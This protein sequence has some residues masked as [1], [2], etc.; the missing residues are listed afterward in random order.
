MFELRR[1]ITHALFMTLELQ[2]AVVNGQTETIKN[3]LQMC[4]S[5]LETFNFRILIDHR[6]FGLLLKLMQIKSFHDTSS[7]LYISTLVL[8]ELVMNEKG[9]F[10][11]F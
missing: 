1:K 11:E 2:D 8:F 5:L 6:L 3:I 4:P 10:F 9:I 7:M